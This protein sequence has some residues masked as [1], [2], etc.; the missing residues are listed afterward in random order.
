MCGFEPQ[1]LGAAPSIP[2]TFLLFNFTQGFIQ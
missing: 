2:A 1:E